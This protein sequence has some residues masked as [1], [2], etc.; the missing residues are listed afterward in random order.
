MLPLGA[1]ARARDWYVG[2]RDASDPEISPLMG[3]CRD[4]PP[5]LIYASTSELLCDDSLLLAR[6]ASD[7]GVPVE[8]ALWPLMPHAFPL[9]EDWISEAKDAR[10]DVA[11]FIK[12]QLNISKNL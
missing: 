2:E 11:A 12:Q 1:L 9:L 3:D 5:L 4:L 10:L 6:K 8:L 7:A